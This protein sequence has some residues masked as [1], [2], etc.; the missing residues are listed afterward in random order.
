MGSSK[1]DTSNQLK[2]LALLFFRLGVTAFGGPAAHIAMMHDEVVKRRKWL[3]EQQ[4]LDL[5]GATN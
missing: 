2:E 1:Q 4:F 3:D 5:M